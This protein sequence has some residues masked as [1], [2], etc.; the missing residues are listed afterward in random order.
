MP[1]SIPARGRT[2]H[3]VG[4]CIN[5]IGTLETIKARIG[6]SETAKFQVKQMSDDLEEFTKSIERVELFS[7]AWYYKY[8][9]GMGES[10]LGNTGWKSVDR[11]AGAYRN[12]P[13]CKNDKT[14][15]DTKSNSI[16][17]DKL[18]REIAGL[19]SQIDKITRPD[20]KSYIGDNCYRLPDA[21]PEATAICEQ[22]YR[23]MAALPPLNANNAD[24]IR[25]RLR[26]VLS[27]MGGL[28]QQ[29]RSRA[30]FWS[31]AHIAFPLDWP[32]ERPWLVTYASILSLFADRIGQRSDTLLKQVRGDD[33]RELPLSVALRETNP[34]AYVKQYVWNDAVPGAFHVF[35]YNIGVD[36]R[37]RV[38]GLEHLY[39][40]ENWTNINTVH[41][42]G[43]GTVRM[44]L[45]KDD[46]GNWNLKSFDQDPSQLVNAYKDI[47]IAVLQKSVEIA[48]KIAADTAV[49]GGTLAIQQLSGLANQV[50]FGRAQAQ[51]PTLGSQSVADLH[52]SAASRI[53][54]VKKDVTN[55]DGNLGTEIGDATSG[56]TQKLQVA[57]AAANEKRKT[58]DAQ[59]NK[60]EAAKKK[61]N[62]AEF[63]GLEAIRVNAAETDLRK[64]AAAQPAGSDERKR[65]EARAEAL[66]DEA[67]THKRTADNLEDRKT[68]LVAA[69][70]DF[71]K[72]EADLKPL[73]EAEAAEKKKLGDLKRERES[74]P[75]VAK[76]SIETILSEHAAVIDALQAGVAR[77]RQSDGGGTG[78]IPA[79]LP[80]Q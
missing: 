61:V 37:A 63:A 50:A 14:K 19:H 7:L 52:A 64:Q 67:V 66:K 57:T 58:V 6:L 2:L 4:V 40:D 26:G 16:M 41:A 69:G 43:R 13:D 62:E 44:A 73:E 27:E 36:S 54:T 24:E 46:I 47:G 31:S 56:Q 1:T 30:M 60:V 9:H 77:K 45:I 15:Y 51:G 18:A 11:A 49:P 22:M 53:A 10:L 76:A 59:R 70:N 74:L 34:A 32:H 8:Y 33:R 79:A 12:P 75:A 78:V 68:G 42:S 5:R 20:P 55:R 38:R 35:G 3:V 29:F 48:G 28:A 21:S 80:R 39:N 23:H 65:L 71:Q 25:A 17:F 72:A